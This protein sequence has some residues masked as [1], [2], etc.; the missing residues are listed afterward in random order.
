MPDSNEI[1]TKYSGLL[2]LQSSKGGQYAKS[3]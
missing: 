3:K 1:T 2:T